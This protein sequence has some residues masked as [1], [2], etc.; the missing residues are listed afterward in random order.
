[1]SALKSFKD[2][3][4]IVNLNGLVHT[5]DRLALKDLTRQMQL[6]NV[7][8]D[9]VFGTFAE[10]LSFLLDCLKSG[11]KKRSKPVIFVLDEFDLFCGHH[12]QTLLYNLFDVAQS[13]QVNISMRKKEYREHCKKFSTNEKLQFYRCQYVYWE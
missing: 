1:M 9:K 13:S 4:M 5:D 8:G 12:N 11:D 3:A 6:E 7:V 10:N 2:N